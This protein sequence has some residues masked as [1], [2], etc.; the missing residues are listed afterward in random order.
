MVIS[1]F[2]KRLLFAREIE[3]DKELKVLGNREIMVSPEFIV[4]LQNKYAKQIYE[5]AEETFSNEIEHIK[6][7]TG[8]T[9]MKL[10]ELSLNLLNLYGLGKFEIMELKKKEVIINLTFSPFAKLSKGKNCILI[11]GALAGVFKI[12]FN[13]KVRC[14]EVVC[15]GEGKLYCQFVVKVKG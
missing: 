5:F 10:L 6:N 9:G 13:K 4:K 15:E 12:F 3:I 14:E 2:F 11:A 1:T 8:V 7:S